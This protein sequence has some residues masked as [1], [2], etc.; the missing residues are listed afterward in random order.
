MTAR[1][2]LADPVRWC[3]GAI[4]RDAA[5]KSSETWNPRAVAW[6]VLGAVR[7]VYPQGLAEFQRLAKT[8]AARG[9]DSVSEWN[10]APE[11]THAEV[12]ALL[13]EVQL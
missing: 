1:E 6:C 4:A 8:L 12:L 5:G 3:Q 2:L 10:D 9:F 7:K 11:R 13:E